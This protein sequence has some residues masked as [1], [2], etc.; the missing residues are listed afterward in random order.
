MSCDIRTVLA[1]P[2]FTPKHLPGCLKWL[3]LRW[4]LAQLSTDASEWPDQWQEPTEPWVGRCWTPS[5]SEKAEESSY[6]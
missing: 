2:H 3:F 6:I 1:S 5:S 4:L